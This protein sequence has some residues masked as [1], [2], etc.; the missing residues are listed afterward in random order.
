MKSGDFFYLRNYP[1]RLLR[2]RRSKVGT[3]MI[4]AVLYIVIYMKNI[5]NLEA[6]IK[7]AAENLEGPL[8]NDFAKLLWDVSVKNYTDI[9]DALSNYL[10]QWK[11]YN[12]WND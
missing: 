6:A 8:P 7:F 2:I 1:K 12:E 11:D 4:L 10:E 9:I 5:S 3:E